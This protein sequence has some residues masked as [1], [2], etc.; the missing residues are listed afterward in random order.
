[1]E[2]H[3]ETFEGSAPEKLHM[4]CPSCAKLYEVEEKDIHSS[5]PQFQC[6][7]CQTRFTFSYPPIDFRNIACRICD[8]EGQDAFDDMMK[9]QRSCPKCGALSPR[10]AEECYSCH[11]IFSRLDGL[12]QDPALRAQ[13]SLV[14]KWKAVVDDFE[15]EKAHEDFIE[16]CQRLE[17]LNF[18]VSKYIDMKQALGGDEVCE[19]RLRQL[20]AL[21]DLALRQSV[22][23]AA[24]RPAAPAVVYNLKSILVYLIYGVSLFLIVWGASSLGHRNLVGLG[25]ALACLETGVLLTVRGRLWH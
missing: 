20:Q 12:P 1:M 21:Q 25:V 22:Q 7:A 24:S 17:A 11:V 8:A 18:A 14:R 13:P 10:E 2:K 6:V 19:Q 9:S 3:L 23:P 5:E 16:S 4:R 15:N